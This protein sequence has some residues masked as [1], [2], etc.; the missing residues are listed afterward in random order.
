[1]DVSILRGELE[2]QGKKATVVI[3]NP[4]GISCRDCSFSGINDIKLIAGSSTCKFSKTFTISDI[5]SSVVFDMRNKLD[6][7]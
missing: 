3:A 2:L 4:N 1:K 5:G 7:N 6:N